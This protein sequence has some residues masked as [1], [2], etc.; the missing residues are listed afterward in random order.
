MLLGG[1]WHGAGWPFVIWGAL[2][3]G[4]LAINHAWRKI[5]VI[6]GLDLDSKPA[7]KFFSWLTTFTAVVVAW[8]YFR[9]PTLE[10][11]N[12]ILLA[13]IGS[14]GAEIPSGILSRLGAAAELLQSIGIE[15]GTGSGTKLVANYVWVLVSGIAALFLPNVAQIF[16]RHEPVL[17]EHE[18]SFQ[19]YLATPRLNWNTSWFWAIVSAG[20]FLLGVLTLTQISEFLYFQF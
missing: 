5:L 20:M 8:V 4:Y 19:N 18:R 1:L 11:G 7:Y 16:H 12:A 2:H 17:Y 10:H 9:A 6:V 3:G 14:N 13:M 15:T